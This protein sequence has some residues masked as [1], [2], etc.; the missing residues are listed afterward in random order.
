MRIATH[1]SVTGERGC[2]F[3]SWLVTPFS[4]CQSKTLEEQYNAGCRYFDVRYRFDGSIY[5][6]AHGFWTS[7][8]T[9]CEVL[10]WMHKKGDCFC[11][12]TCERGEPMSAD[13]IDRFIDV[14]HRVKFTT[15]NVKHPEWEVVKWCSHP[16]PH[17][18]A[19]KVLNWD[20]WHSL[21]PIPW[22][23]KKIYHDKPHFD[24][25]VFSFVDFL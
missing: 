20:S 5:R 3:L 21:L 2:G 10:G 1:N 4:K 25:K 14:F 17:I 11:M 24:N 16:I 13:E 22:L 6:C 15:F 8:K 7:K 9:L 23:W 12:M 19:Y 18:N